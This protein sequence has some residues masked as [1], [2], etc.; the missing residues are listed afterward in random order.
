MANCNCGSC[1]WCIKDKQGDMICG[2]DSSEYVA[3]Y[4]SEEHWCEEYQAEEQED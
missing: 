3:D 1:H 4:V 2:N